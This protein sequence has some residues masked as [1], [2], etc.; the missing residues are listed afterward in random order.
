VLLNVGSMR[1]VNLDVFEFDYDLTWMVF[2]LNAN[3]KVYG[4]YGGRPPENVHQY[5]SLPGLRN[6]MTAALAAHKRD[7]DARPNPPLPAEPRRVEQ[8]PPAQRFAAKSC[9]HCHHV[10]D[11]RREDLQARGKWTTGEVWVYPYPENVGLTIDV[12]AGNRVEQVAA[13]SAAARAGIRPDDRLLSVNGVSIASFA[14]VTYALHKSPLQGTVPVVWQRQGEQLRG[15]LGLADGWRR[16]DLSW[17]WS[18]RGL[19]PAPGVDGYDLTAEERKELGLGPK[20]LAFRQ[21][22]FVPLP[23]QQAGIRINDVIVGIDG[24][25]PEL[26][27]R[28]FGAF[29]RLNYRPGDLVTYNLIRDGKRLDVKLKL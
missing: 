11:L 20:Q 16:T 8:L 12:K 2:F 17:R 27:F 24:K 13:G 4:R 26:T 9:F 21:G 29:V 3:E 15:E 5:W 28:Q 7:P 18:L 1:G 14:D 25:Q 19:A 22:A 10:W 6:A 23:A